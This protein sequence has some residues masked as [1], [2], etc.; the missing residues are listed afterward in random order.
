MQ[1]D[2]LGQLANRLRFAPLIEGPD[3]VGADEKISRR[4]RVPALELG[5]RMD[6]VRHALSLYLD[7]IDIEPFVIRGEQPNHL[8]PL[9]R[10]SVAWALQRLGS[11]GNEPEGVELQCLHR[12]RCREQVAGVRRVERSAEDA[13]SHRQN[14]GGVGGVGGGDAGAAVAGAALQT[15]AMF[16]SEGKRPRASAQTSR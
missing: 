1:H 2:D 5:Q 14:G 10:R 8:E 12:I 11:V 9:S 13:E 4:R 16:E 6:G 7:R 15:E 3:D